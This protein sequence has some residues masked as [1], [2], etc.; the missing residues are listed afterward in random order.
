MSSGDEMKKTETTAKDNTKK[1]N[2]KRNLCRV[3]VT[4]Q[5]QGARKESEWPH[6]EGRWVFRLAQEFSNNEVARKTGVSLRQESR[7]PSLKTSPVT[8]SRS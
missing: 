6:H 4:F 8:K 3:P 1:S 5:V 7:S 2:E